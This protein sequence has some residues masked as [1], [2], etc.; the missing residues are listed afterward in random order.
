M[1]V[2][3]FVLIWLALA[4]C[5]WLFTTA[6]P[7]GPVEWLL[8]LVA[9]PPAYVLLSV[10]GELLGEAFN[11]LPGV[12]QGNAFVERRTTGAQVSGLRIV[13]YLFTGLI[14]IATVIALTWLLRHYF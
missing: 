5:A 9:G 14:A 13:W 4:F 12:R 10:V 6:S 11:R 2:I 7:S 3:S 8:L 1:K